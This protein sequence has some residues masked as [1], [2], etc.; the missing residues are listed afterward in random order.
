MSLLSSIYKIDK[1]EERT[2]NNFQAKD[3]YENNDNII[4]LRYGEYNDD[5]DN[6]YYERYFNKNVYSKLK[7]GI[8]KFDCDRY[9][10]IKVFNKENNEIN[11]I[12]DVIK[13][14]QNKYDW[15]YITCSFR[16]ALEKLDNN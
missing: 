4:F 12:T 1:W 3:K 2:P 9:G 8:Y 10:K 7:K 11:I 5:Y 6:G 13:K 16:K 14:E 15:S